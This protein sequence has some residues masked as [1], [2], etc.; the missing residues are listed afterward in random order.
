[1]PRSE[2]A[3]MEPGELSDRLA[4][5][6]RELF[7]LRFQRATGQL[8]NT[9]R[10]GQVRR[11]VARVL[12]FLRQQDLGID[13]D[14]EPVGTQPAGAQTAAEPSEAAEEAGR[15]TR[16]LRRGRAAAVG[17]EAADEPSEL[18]AEPGT[19]G[20]ADDDAGDADRVAEDSEEA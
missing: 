8:D 13:V 10:L 5:A 18:E 20:S 16:R 4:E 19:Q 17:S 3:G 15:R 6:R 14:T 7:N 1:M 12:T 11:E 9:A 2:L